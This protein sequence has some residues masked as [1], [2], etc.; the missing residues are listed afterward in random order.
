LKRVQDPRAP[1]GFARFLRRHS[2]DEMPQF[3]HL[4][5]GEMSS[6][7]PRPMTAGELRD[8]YRADAGEILRVR[9]GIDGLW[10]VSGRN[11]LDYAER[12][13]LDLRLVRRRS[14]RLYAGVPLRTI[15]EGWNGA[16]SW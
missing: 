10:R 1:N 16:N 12:R 6:V 8:F 4:M 11:R 7:G 2:I 5:R 3:W 9:P 13:R 15:P 14:P